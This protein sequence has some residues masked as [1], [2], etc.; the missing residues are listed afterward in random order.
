MSQPA[1]HRSPGHANARPNLS[2]GKPLVMQF[3][4]L[5][6]SIQFLNSSSQASLFLSTRA[7]RTH[8]FPLR[9]FGLCSLVHR[10]G[11]HAQAASDFSEASS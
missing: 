5:L 4:H 9:G 1:L 8:F 6:V 10:P 3:K 7:S 2:R 11:L